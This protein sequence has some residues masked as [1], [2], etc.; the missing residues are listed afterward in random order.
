[1]QQRARADAFDPE[2]RYATATL[3]VPGMGSDH[4]AFP[5]ETRDPPA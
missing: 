1:M 3:L 2:V 5:A 4:S